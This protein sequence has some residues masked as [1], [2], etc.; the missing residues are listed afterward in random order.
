MDNTRK[1]NLAEATVES[2]E[3]DAEGA[4]FKRALLTSTVTPSYSYVKA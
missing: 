3:S 1:Y 4:A 2:M